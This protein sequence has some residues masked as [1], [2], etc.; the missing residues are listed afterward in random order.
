MGCQ[1]LV[2]NGIKSAYLELKDRVEMPSGDSLTSMIRGIVGEMAES[3]TTSDILNLQ[4][5]LDREIVKKTL[6]LLKKEKVIKL[7]GSGR[8]AKWK[9]A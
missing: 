8:G 7:I 3:F 4:P 9:R 2:Q 6:S 1:F 5:G